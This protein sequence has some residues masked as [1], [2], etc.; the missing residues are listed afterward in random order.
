MLPYYHSTIYCVFTHELQV[1]GR[2]FIMEKDLRNRIIIGLS[3]VLVLIFSLYVLFGANGILQVQKLKKQKVDM[4]RK[5]QSLS[6][7]NENLKEEINRLESDKKYLEKVVRERL[8]LVKPDETIIRF[9]A[10]P[11]NKS[12]DK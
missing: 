3:I 8:R 10:P 9:Q 2:F 1:Q 11:E 7:E 6:L 4:D 5:V 12:G